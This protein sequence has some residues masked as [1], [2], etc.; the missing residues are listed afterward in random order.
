[1]DV[2]TPFSNADKVPIRC[3][4]LID[5]RQV[6]AGVTL[7]MAPTMLRL[8]AASRGDIGG[9]PVNLLSEDKGKSWC[10]GWNG[11]AA[12]ALMAAVLLR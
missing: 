2:L 9:A 7:T 12:R 10:R 11:D 5:G 6:A 8:R 1:M 4:V 3:R